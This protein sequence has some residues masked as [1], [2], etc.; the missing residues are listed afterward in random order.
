MH[1][2]EMSVR[3]HLVQSADSTVIPVTFLL[4]AIGAIAAHF[5]GIQRRDI[6][7][8]VL[9]V[10]LAWLVGHVVVVGVFFIMDKLGLDKP[11]N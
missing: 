7:E 3:E 10:P 11:R 8:F 1:Y 4:V 2:Y 9:K 6:L 5:D